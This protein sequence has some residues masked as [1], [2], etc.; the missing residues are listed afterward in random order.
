MEPSTKPEGNVEP[1][2]KIADN[3]G[4]LADLHARH[5]ERI[6]AQH[7][8]IA[9]ITARLGRPGLFYAEVG[10]VGLWVTLWAIT[11]LEHWREFDP[12]P[13]FLLQGLVGFSALLLTTMILIAQNR[14][15]HIL[16]RRA[17]IETQVVLSIEQKAAKAIELLEELRRDLP[18]RDRTDPH[19]EA[20]KHPTDPK[21]VAAELDQVSEDP[22]PDQR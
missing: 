6:P 15:R 19:A 22:E 9:T 21:A 7:R 4:L 14:D 2:I 12:A 8:A 11:R 16:E 10:L 3:V 13:F 5:E 1:G 20:M 17:E 18:I